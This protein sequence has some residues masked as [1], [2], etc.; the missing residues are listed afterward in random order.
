MDI[1]CCHALSVLRHNFDHTANCFSTKIIITTTTPFSF[2]PNLIFRDFKLNIYRLDQASM[3]FKGIEKVKR[4][5]ILFKYRS[6]LSFEYRISIMNLSADF[7]K[8]K[9]M[10]TQ[11]LKIYFVFP[12]ILCMCRIIM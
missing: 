4:D 8:G 3:T 9:M 1:F 10:I 11:V 2:I 5:S 7:P 6:F 12:Y